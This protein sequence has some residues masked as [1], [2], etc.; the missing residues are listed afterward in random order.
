[1]TE[2]GLD[3]WGLT[4][5]NCL[6]SASI[7]AVGPAQCILGGA[8]GVVECGWGVILTSYFLLVQW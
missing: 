4:P 5:G 7:L 3:D 2:H 1:V 8:S 6:L